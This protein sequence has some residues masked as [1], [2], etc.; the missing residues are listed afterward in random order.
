MP[1]GDEFGI[2]RGFAEF[3]SEAIPVLK[4]I[5]EK[6]R[7]PSKEKYDILMNY[8]ALQIVRTPAYR[9]DF[10]KSVSKIYDQIGKLSLHVLLQSK[11]YFDKY[12]DEMLQRKPHLRKEDFNYEKIYKEY[13]NITIQAEIDQNYHVK[14]A[15]KMIDGLLPYL[16]SR[17]W[18]VLSPIENKQHFITSDNPV[19][20][21]WSEPSNFNIPIGYGLRNTDI[22]FPINKEVVIR[23]RFESQ[24]KIAHLNFESLA[25]MN[26]Y[27][28]N[29]SDRYLY[30]CE[31]EISW[32]MPDERVGNLAELLIFIK[33]SN[34]RT[35][36]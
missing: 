34:Q 2:E 6:K 32:Y 20:L 30:S 27:I 24:P 13:K 4:E 21:I 14:H 31:R 15:I 1:G 9:N 35:Q 11:E 3:E 36:Q 29:F 17:N 18:S 10:E 19:V 7:L 33:N 16:G 5:G 26:N 25:K 12:V 23:G 8:V 22:I 28:A